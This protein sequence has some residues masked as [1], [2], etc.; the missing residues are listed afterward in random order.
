M[1]Q[2]DSG[3]VSHQEVLQFQQLSQRRR[4]PTINTSESLF[5]RLMIDYVSL[6]R[7][8]FLETSHPSTQSQKL[9]TGYG[10]VTSKSGW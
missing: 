6:W 5:G 3:I 10:S 9:K 2:F 7:L 8:Y 1:S 4:W